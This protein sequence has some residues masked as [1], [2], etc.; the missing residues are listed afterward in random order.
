MLLFV[1]GMVLRASFDDFLEEADLPDDP[2]PSEKSKW[3]V[4]RG[5][6]CARGPTD[7]QQVRLPSLAKC[8]V[9]ASVSEP[10][11]CE[12]AARNSASAPSRAMSS[13]PAHVAESSCTPQRN[14]AKRG[15][16]SLSFTPPA[17]PNLQGQ[18]SCDSWC[19]SKK[20]K[21]IAEK[22]EFELEA[23]VEAAL[24]AEGS[25]GKHTSTPAE[26]AGVHAS[27]MQ[28]VP[29]TGAA[30]SLVC[31]T[32]S[33]ETT[34]PLGKRS[35][36]KSSSFEELRGRDMVEVPI[37]FFGTGSGNRPK[38]IRIPVL[39]FW[40]GEEVIYQKLSG[41]HGLS[42]KAVLLNRCGKRW[43]QLAIEDREALLA[44]RDREALAIEDK[45]RLPALKDKPR[46][47]RKKR[48]VE[49]D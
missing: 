7:Q 15:D 47:Q 1:L 49:D 38:R 48:R 35:R 10:A 30:T 13:I 25:S 6:A 24:F 40:R 28:L 2:L 31:T 39:E 41:H 5:P 42:V 12:A 33:D 26:A 9:R 32:S 36:K 19:S 46:Q 45:P 17:L 37:D 20:R 34:K 27:N 43:A 8:R 11:L 3:P 44:I 29:Y 14:R 4:P 21:R 23:A 18:A 16:N 22:T